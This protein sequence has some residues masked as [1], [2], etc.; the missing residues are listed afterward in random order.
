MQIIKVQ[1]FATCQFLCTIVTP[2]M[3]PFKYSREALRVVEIYVQSM[4]IFE[5]KVTSSTEDSLVDFLTFL[6]QKYSFN[7]KGI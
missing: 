6:L 7:F 4:N 1:P 2:K 3:T 5:K